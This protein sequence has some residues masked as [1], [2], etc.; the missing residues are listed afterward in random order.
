[1][2]KAAAPAHGKAK[3]K[4]AWRLRLQKTQA[5]TG[6]LVEKYNGNWRKMDDFRGKKSGLIDVDPRGSMIVRVSLVETMRMGMYEAT[7]CEG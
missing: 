4:N 2:A 6:L 5:R 3:A 1:M 7:L